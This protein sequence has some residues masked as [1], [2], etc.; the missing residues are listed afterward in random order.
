MNSHCQPERPAIPCNSSKAPEMGPA[1][2]PASAVAVIKSATARACSQVLR[3]AGAASVWVATVA[4]AQRRQ[5]EA[6]RA[7]VTIE[8]PM[9]QDIAM[10]DG[11]TTLQ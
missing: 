7:P 1:I 5:I 4:R 9:H 2:T 10:W 8:V 3:R 11:G 6:Y